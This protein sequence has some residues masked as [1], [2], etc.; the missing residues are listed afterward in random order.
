[1]QLQ[2]EYER[3]SQQLSL[4][5][6]H[7]TT[8]NPDKHP[9]R[10]F[11]D[12]YERVMKENI[13]LKAKAEGSQEVRHLVEALMSVLAIA[14]QYE[15]TRSLLLGN[16][17]AGYSHGTALTGAVDCSSVLVGKSASSGLRHP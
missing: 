12:E 8:V 10:A 14:M 2:A 5:K 16:V 4:A 6:R 1:M 9:P 13:A 3:N 15:A 17:S 7:L 11:R